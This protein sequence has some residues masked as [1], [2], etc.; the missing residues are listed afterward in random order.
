MKNVIECYDGYEV[1]KIEKKDN[2]GKDYKPIGNPSKNTECYFTNKTYV[3]YRLKYS[4][5]KN[6]KFARLPLLFMRYISF[7]K[8]CL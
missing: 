4:R 5:G 2:I 8:N 6:W 1:I 7:Y 3:A